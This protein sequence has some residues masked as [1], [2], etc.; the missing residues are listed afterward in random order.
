MT[1]KSLCG[2]WNVFFPDSAGLSVSHVGV[3]GGRTAKGIDLVATLPGFESRIWHLLIVWLSASLWTLCTSVFSSVKWGGTQRGLPHRIWRGFNEYIQ[4]AYNSAN[5]ILSAT[6]VFDVIIIIII[7]RR[8]WPYPS[9]LFL[10]P[11]EELREKAKF[12]ISIFRSNMV[13]QKSV[14]IIH[15]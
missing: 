1:R 13:W 11:Q 4:N 8:W 9:I 7:A 5:Y 10:Q 12:P 15:T 3:I 14:G 2:F 6:P